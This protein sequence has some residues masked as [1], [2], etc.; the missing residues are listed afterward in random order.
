[1]NNHESEFIRYFVKPH[2][3]DRWRHLLADPSNTKNRTKLTTRRLAS[4]H[5]D[6]RYALEDEESLVNT[7]RLLSA[8]AARGAPNLCYVLS[9]NRTIDGRMMPLDDALDEV[10]GYGR[11]TVISC[12]PGKLAFLEGERSRMMFVRHK[13][14]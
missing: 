5:F 1:M 9:E 2:R 10:V 14:V 13:V 7:S 8:L 12:V 11:S 4:R 6:S 3:R